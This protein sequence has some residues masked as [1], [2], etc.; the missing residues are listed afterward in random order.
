VLDDVEVD[1]RGGLPVRAR[2]VEDRLYAFDGVLWRP[3]ARLPFQGRPRPSEG[4]AVRV[5]DEA[6]YVAHIRDWLDA[7]DGRSGERRLLTDP[8]GYRSLRA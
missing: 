5:G 4:V 7:R 8:A 1:V 2:L 3:W 6:R